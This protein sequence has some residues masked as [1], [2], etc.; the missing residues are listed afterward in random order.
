MTAVDPYPSPV[1]D[2]AAVPP[3]TRTVVDRLAADRPAFHGAHGH[4]QVWNLVTEALDVIARVVQP[5]DATLECGSGASTVVFTATGAR[6]TAISPFEA[7]HERIRA[8]LAQLGIDDSGL[9]TVAG[10]SQDVLP[11]LDGQLD[12]VL[13]DGLH[14]F[15]H[16]MVDWYYATRLLRVGGHLLMD[17]IPIPAV[18][19]A[20]RFMRM[21]PGWELVEVA[22]DRVAVFRKLAEPAPGDDWLAQPFNARPDYAFAGRRRAAALHARDAAS[23]FAARHPALG[24]L[25]RRIAGRAR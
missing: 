22:G 12:V 25:R 21:D 3:S 18:A 5:G 7:E 19:V 6:H 8:Y 4:E 13:I 2:R 10:R 1:V 15:P 17:D 16:P 11:G 23:A 9:H 20:F 14:K 24:R